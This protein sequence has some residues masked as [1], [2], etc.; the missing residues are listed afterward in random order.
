VVDWAERLPG[1]VYDIMWN[2]TTNWFAVTIYRDDNV[3]R[4]D[5]RPG[6][7]AG[8]PRTQDVLGASTPRAILAALDVAPED[9][10]YLEA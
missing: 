10:G 9:L 6:Q 5:N 7:D 8:F 1:P 4:W 2:A 3:V